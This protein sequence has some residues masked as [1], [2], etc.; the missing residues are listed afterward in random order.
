MKGC[1]ILGEG[2]YLPGGLVLGKVMQL[3]QYTP[4]GRTNLVARAPECLFDPA[5]HLAWST[6]RLEIVAM[7][8]RFV[9]ATRHGF[10]ANLTNTTLTLSNRV[11][12][13]LQQNLMQF[14]PPP[15]P[16]P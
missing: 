14:A 12:T 9:L 2:E 7:D 16:A 13:V 5:A 4:E 15:S 8:G 11:R 1:L 6:G 10:Q 3:E